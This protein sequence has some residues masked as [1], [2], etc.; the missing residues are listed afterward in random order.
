ML[1]V[2]MRVQVKDEEDCDYLIEALDRD[3]NLALLVRTD[4]HAHYVRFHC[5]H[6]RLIHA[7]RLLCGTQHNWQPNG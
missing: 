4:E 1:E 6:L 3:N 7:T 5:A 2:G